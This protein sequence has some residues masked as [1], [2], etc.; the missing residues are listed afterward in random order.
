M[1]T[2][3]INVRYVSNFTGSNGQI[4][5]THKN[6]YFF[7]DFRYKEQSEKQIN[8][9]F[10]IIIY[11]NFFSSLKKIL[12]KENLKKVGFESSSLKFYEY[13]KLKKI[14]FIEWYPIENLIE[15]FR[16]IKKLEEVNLIKRAVE[17]SE[18]SLKNCLFYLSASTIPITE[19][20]FALKLEFEM[21]KNGAEGISFPTITLT[22]ENSSIVHGS[23]GNFLIKNH[24]L[25][26][27][28]CKYKGYCSDKTV[29]L[30][31]DNEMKK[32]F[33]IVRDAKNFAIDQIKPGM[34]A[35]DI[36]KIARDF[37][38]KKGFGKFFGH[39]LGHGIGLEVHE[40]PVIGP[41]SKD[42]IENGNV[43]TIEPGIYIPKKGG[44]RL[45]DIVFIN[46]KEVELLTEKAEEI[47]KCLQ[48]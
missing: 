45:E 19:K 24:I 18:F 33:T 48:V 3:L 40:Y 31:F 8:K 26:D 32:I 35:K 13:T 36:D 1:I 44:V 46:D 9:E 23:P 21:L 25:I 4:L 34:K 2:N 11:S 14:N 20:E 42:I 41:K 30:T 38:D 29:T 17:I 47:E 16:K 7:T 43:F 28:G 10:K 6:L 15:N 37:I 39:S 12:K 5:I 27:F 22:G